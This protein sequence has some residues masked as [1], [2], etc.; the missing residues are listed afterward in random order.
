MSL[1]KEFYEESIRLTGYAVDVVRAILHEQP[2][3]TGQEVLAALMHNA[4]V[5]ASASTTVREKCARCGAEIETRLVNGQQVGEPVHTSE[6][7]RGCRAASYVDS[8]GWD[9]A[10]PRS[11]TAKRPK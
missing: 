9:N 11:W 2:A 8:E 6:G 5:A 7:S 10:I 4:E 1:P 3:M